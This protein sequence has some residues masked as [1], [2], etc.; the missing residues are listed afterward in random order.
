MRCL[1]SRYGFESWWLPES[2]DSL[3]SYDDWCGLVSSAVHEREEVEWRTRMQGKP[4]LDVYR[5][6]KRDLA[7]EDYL[8]C[9]V[10]SRDAAS[11]R[12]LLRSG[13]HDLE[14]SAARRRVA[15]DRLP[16]HERVCRVCRSGVPEDLPH[17]PLDCPALKVERA[18]LFGRVRAKVDD[19]ASL[20]PLLTL[21]RRQR[22]HLLL[23]APPRGPEFEW[24]KA[25]AVAMRGLDHD[26]LRGVF[27][28]FRRRRRLLASSARA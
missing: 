25:D 16:R 22:V 19:L 8:A 14:V 4:S 15:A 20:A 5:A 21:S 23:G 1:F 2:W 24:S 3:P 18:S 6:A 9:D 10:A 26:L 12:V 13:V 17:F 27:A 11:L 7:F 28:M